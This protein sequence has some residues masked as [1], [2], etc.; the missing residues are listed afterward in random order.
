MPNLAPFV[1]VGGLLW[2][3]WVLLWREP[4]WPVVLA[5]GVFPLG[6][7]LARRTGHVSLAF[8]SS[9]FR[10]DLWAL[11]FGLVAWRVVLAV[12]RTAWNGLTGSFQPGVVA[13]PL[14]LRTEMAQL[15][16]LWAITVTPGTIALLL[17][18]DVL[19]V[20]CLHPPAGPH[21]PGV[22][23]LQQVLAR[24]WE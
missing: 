9:I 1:L 5:G 2:G 12:A 21:I 19:Y 11:F 24:I 16:L 22:D 6:V 4:G 18:E 14:R 17:E 23:R 20:H 15:L 13:I 8:P 3:L 10:L 7:W